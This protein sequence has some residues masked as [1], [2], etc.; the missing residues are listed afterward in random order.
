MNFPKDY[1]QALDW[2]RKAAEQGDTQAQYFLGVMLRDGIGTERDYEGAYFWL[3]VVN[4]NY[5]IGTQGAL[6]RAAEHLSAEQKEKID[7]KA[8]DWKKTEKGTVQQMQ[9]LF[10]G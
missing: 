5:G 9:R 3:G 4:K 10:M 1:R 2:F 8:R 6:A 7:I